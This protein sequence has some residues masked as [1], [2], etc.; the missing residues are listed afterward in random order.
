MN[1]LINIIMTKKRL[2][3]YVANRDYDNREHLSNDNLN[4][5]PIV[6][7][8]DYEEIHIVGGEPLID[9][10]KLYNFLSDANNVLKILYG[11]SPKIC[12]HTQLWR[13][14]ILITISEVCDEL[15]INLIDEDDFD[16]FKELNDIL[17]DK[18]SDA[19]YHFKGIEVNVKVWAGFNIDD[20]II[21]PAWNVSY[22]TD[23][24][25]KESDKR[26]LKEYF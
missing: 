7:D 11:H 17:D 4:N 6:S 15:N 3:L 10:G 20:M 1:H 22:M 18:E 12:L 14:P 16:T 9:Y 13:I 2:S 5:I 21:S 24:K 26:R 19:Y 23:E 8:L 25:E